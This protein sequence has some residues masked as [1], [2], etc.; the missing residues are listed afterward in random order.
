MSLMRSIYETSDLITHLM[1]TPEDAAEWSRTLGGR[2]G[3]PEQIEGRKLFNWRTV[4]RAI[5]EKGGDATPDEIVSELNLA[6]HPTEWAASAYGIRTAGS[7]DVGISSQVGFSPLST[8]TTLRYLR[9]VLPT[10]INAFLTHCPKFKIK[11]SAW[12]KIGANYE[13]LHEYWKGN[14]WVSDRML[15]AMRETDLRLRNGEDLETVK[16]D[17]ESRFEDSE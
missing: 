12:R 2:P 15:E 14:N 10:P 5:Q 11:K 8:Y 17:I 6:V 3:S 4:R 16:A 1:L 7:S 13:T 9:A